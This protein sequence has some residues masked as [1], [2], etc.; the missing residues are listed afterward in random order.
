[1]INDWST[2]YPTITIHY[3]LI[4]LML[5]WFNLNREI[6]FGV[7]LPITPFITSI[8][9]SPV[10]LAIW[11]ALGSAIFSRIALLFASNRIF[12]PVTEKGTLKHN[13]QSDFKAYLKQLI[14]FQEK[15][16]CFAYKM[17]C[18]SVASSTFLQAGYWLNK[19]LIPTKIL[20]L[21]DKL[22]DF[23]MDVIKW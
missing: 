20:Y 15:S 2:D 16:F 9:K 18:K 7:I 11:L 1:M 19:I 4:S 6:D 5:E 3:S 10:I 8:L 17:R 23:K 13:N 14:K 22:C 12:F 21:G